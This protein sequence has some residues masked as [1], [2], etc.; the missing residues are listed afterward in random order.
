MTVTPFHAVEI[1]VYS[2]L[3]LLPYALLSLLM[4]RDSLRFDRLRTALLTA[5]LCAVQ[6]LIGFCA[7]VWFR[8]YVGMVNIV[9]YLV[10]IFSTSTV[11]SSFFMK[12]ALLN[13]SLRCDAVISGWPA[14]IFAAA[15]MT[16]LWRL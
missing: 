1:A 9:G 12:K 2:I 7:T 13:K 14:S 10:Y 3:N 5:A 16:A 6:V 11:C 8:E 15:R 4:F